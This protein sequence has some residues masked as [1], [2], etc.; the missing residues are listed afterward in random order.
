M[1]CS[2]WSCSEAQSAPPPPSLC[3]CVLCCVTADHILFDAASLHATILF[4]FP[5]Q[6]FARCYEQTFTTSPFGARQTGGERETFGSQS[7]VYYQDIGFDV[8]ILL[9]RR[10]SGC[11]TSWLSIS[12]MPYFSSKATVRRERKIRIDYNTSRQ[13]QQVTLTYSHRRG[14][15]SERIFCLQARLCSTN[16]CT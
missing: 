1:F 6:L 10:M 4:F 15:Y 8:H 9:K 14:Y 2:C 7:A 13:H 11:S 16:L 12:L 3:L 5:L